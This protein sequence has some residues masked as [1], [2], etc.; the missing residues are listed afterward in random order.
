MQL[1]NTPFVTGAVI[2]TGFETKV[3]MNNQK[4]V[5][6]SSRLMLMT[7]FH[8][9]CIFIGQLIVAAIASII[10]TTWSID[11]SE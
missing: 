4:N 7:N 3:Q 8:I 5:F 9:L 1:K 2:Y 11:N 6:K 10:G